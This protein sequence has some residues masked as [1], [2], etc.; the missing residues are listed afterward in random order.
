M[1]KLFLDANLVIY[2]NTMTGDERAT[3]DQ[4]FKDLLRDRL[5]INLLVLDEVLYISRSR[6]RVPYAV[7]MNFLRRTLLPY[8]EIIPI[9][10]E[11]LKA[12]ERYLIEYDI[13][14]SDAIHLAT[15]DKAGIT[16]IISE[17][18]ELDKVKGINRIWLEKIHKP[19]RS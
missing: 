1:K 17:D 13:K 3:I 19:L 14:P 11:D 5:F 16:S 4:F 7:T 10:E 2:L 9:A 8:T 12:T 15:M 6:Y 18:K